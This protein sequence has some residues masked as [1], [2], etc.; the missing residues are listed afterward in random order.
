MKKLAVVI[1]FL[2]IGVVG[3]SQNVDRA[4][5][6]ILGLWIDEAGDQIYEFDDHGKVLFQ[7]YVANINRGNR[8]W[9]AYMGSYTVDGKKVVIEY[10]VK[11][12]ENTKEI[13]RINK[14]VELEIYTENVL[15]SLF[16]GRLHFIKRDHGH[17]I[18][19]T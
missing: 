4:G 5:H 14:K 8:H 2:V 17:K 1:L 19:Q 13:E 7:E 15:P 11:Q 9:D 3:Y 12:N 10:T 16:N 6:I 18:P